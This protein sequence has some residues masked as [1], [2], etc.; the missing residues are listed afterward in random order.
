MKQA[1]LYSLILLGLST[2]L[3]QCIAT[4]K[5]MEYTN[6]QV[7]KV[8]SKVEEIDKEIAKLKKQTV[9]EVQERQAETGD[10]LD[11]HQSEILRL[12]GEIEENHFFIQQMNEENKALKKL[13]LSRIKTSEE[14]SSGEINKLKGR[15]ALT[16]DQLLKA[17]DR[18]TF[19]EN[20][21]QAIKDARSQEAAKQ[22]MEAAQRVRETERKAR[23]AAER[24]AAERKAAVRKKSSRGPREIL[25]DPYKIDVSNQNITKGTIEEREEEKTVSKPVKKTTLPPAVTPPQAVTPPPAATPPQAVTPPP[26]ATAT[27]YDRGMTLFKQKKYRDAYN[28]FAEYLDKNPTGPQAV[29]ARYYAAQSLYDD[30]DFELSILEFQK[31]IVEHPQDSLAPKALYKQGLSFEKIGDPETARIVYNKL[32]DTYPGSAEVSSAK[33]RLDALKR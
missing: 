21:I 12:Q 9:K 28:S 30:K 19:A 3:V 32:V 5:D 16:E 27:S 26:A 11:Y 14:N 24:E 17:N 25:P 23:L 15:L 22:A 20:E 8:D 33:T 7:R 6:V 10:R 13:L 18:L 2:M 31:I 29:N 1:F 4:Q